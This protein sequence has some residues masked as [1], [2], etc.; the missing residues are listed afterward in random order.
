MK[1][2]EVNSLDVNSVNKLISQAVEIVCSNLDSGFYGKLGG[3]AWESHGII[4]K[5]GEEESAGKGGRTTLNQT[6]NYTQSSGGC[7]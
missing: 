4:T 5:N 2:F 6:N 1:Y 3:I 7:C